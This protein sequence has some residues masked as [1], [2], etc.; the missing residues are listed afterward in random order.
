[1]AGG[2]MGRILKLRTSFHGSCPVAAALIVAIISTHFPE[3]FPLWQRA[4]YGLI[5]ALLFFAAIGVRESVIA[6][7]AARRRIPEKHLTL[8]IFGGVLR[9]PT[10]TTLPVLE[11]LL[12][13]AG[14]LMNILIAAGFYAFFIVA[15]TAGN[16]VVAALTQWLAYISVLLIL[17][18][19]VPAWPWD[20]GRL[21]ASYLWGPLGSYYR[22]IRVSSWVGS[23]LG[24]GFVLGGIATIAAGKEW[25]T[26]LLMITVGWALLRAAL[27]GRRRAML[28]EALNGCSVGQIATMDSIPIT[29]QMNVGELV[30]DYIL[31]SGQRYFLVI[32]DGRFRGVMTLR[33]VRSVS[34]KRWGSTTVERAMI[35]AAL[36]P[37]VRAEQSANGLLQQM[38]DLGVQELPVLRPDGMVRVIARETVIRLAE[39][40]CS[41]KAQPAEPPISSMTLCVLV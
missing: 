7:L 38:E 9:E 3:A 10:E 29:S 35:P 39:T 6:F 36:M 25:F 11:R 30:K 32:D 14:M 41:L 31:V 24:G 2:K 1:M 34:R 5:V 28:H 37:P 8:Y 12:A 33:R 27:S 22:A 20:A 15:V 23:A 40:R 18:H 21:L 4:F 17:L 26:S 16:E 13:V 19:F